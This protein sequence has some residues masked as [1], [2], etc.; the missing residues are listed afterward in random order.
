M[1]VPRTEDVL[2]KVRA[3]ASEVPKVDEATGYAIPDTYLGSKKKI[4]IIV[5]GFG[6][7][8]INLAHIFGDAANKDVE[9]QCYEKNPEVGGTWYE[10][11]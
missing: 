8:A 7:A 2:D 5:I 4:R 10:N 1:D 6:A 3:Y 9:I 11:R